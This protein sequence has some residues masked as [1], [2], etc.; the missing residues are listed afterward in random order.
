MYVFVDVS[1][2]LQK[3]ARKQGSTPA[4]AKAAADVLPSQGASFCVRFKLA[5]ANLLGHFSAPAFLQG[6]LQAFWNRKVQLHPI[7]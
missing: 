6:Q 7:C 2:P 3:N 4:P 1:S 5:S